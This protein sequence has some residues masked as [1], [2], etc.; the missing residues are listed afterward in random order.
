M[1]EHKGPVDKI[2]EDGDQFAVHGI[3]E[4]FPGKFAVFC[5]RRYLCKIIT[6][7]IHAL[8]ATILL[9]YKIGDII[10]HIEFPV[11]TGTHLI[12]FEVQELIGRNII[13]YNISM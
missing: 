6:K 2:P 10:S 7:H 4:T 13:G 8:A 11:T 12:S 5:F 1:H 9:L 3:L